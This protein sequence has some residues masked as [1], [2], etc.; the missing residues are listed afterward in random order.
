VPRKYARPLARQRLE[1]LERQACDLSYI[2]GSSRN[3]KVNV[4]VEGMASE[5][6]LAP[7]WIMAYRYKDQLYRFLVNG[8]NGHAIGHAPVSWLKIG[9]AIGI[10]VLV[11]V[12]LLLM[13]VGR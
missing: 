7:V 11:L 10:A 3:V 13:M 2:P 6:I 12:I 4:K 5:P 1:E 9:T 8:Q